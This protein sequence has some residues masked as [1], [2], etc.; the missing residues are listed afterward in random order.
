MRSLKMLGI[1]CVL[2]AG[3][4]VLT[5]VK[6]P[7]QSVASDPTAVAIKSAEI[8]VPTGIPAVDCL[9]SSVCP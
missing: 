7:P 4:F 1:A 8:Q 9:I 3:A 5:M 6:D 2:A